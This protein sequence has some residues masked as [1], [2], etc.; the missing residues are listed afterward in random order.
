MG[1]RGLE[2]GPYIPLLPFLLPPFTKP[3]KNQTLEGRLC[4]THGKSPAVF[5]PDIRDAHLDPLSILRTFASVLRTQL[6][7]C[8]FLP[9]SLIP[10][11]PS[12]LYPSPS[13]PCSWQV[14]IKWHSLLGRNCAERHFLGLWVPR[15]Q[16]QTLHWEE[17]VEEV[18]EKTFLAYHVT[19]RCLHSGP[20]PVECFW[21][22]GMGWIPQTD[23]LNNVDSQ[24]RTLFF[25]VCS[26][27]L[28][29]C[30]G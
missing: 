14:F 25:S 24:V 23:M 6:N 26:H 16:E 3:L 13:P 2:W 7:P 10:Y 18:A 5:V 27:A 4:F 20:S 1:L 22:P 29:L 21:K 19:A 28:W 15:G 17:H 9:R 11:L 12:C 30:P 8:P